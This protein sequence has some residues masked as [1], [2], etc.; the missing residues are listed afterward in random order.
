MGRDDNVRALTAP[1]AF[2]HI[3]DTSWFDWVQYNSSIEQPMIRNAGEAMGVGA[4]VNW[5]PSKGPLFTSTIPPDRLYAIE[6]RL[7]GPKQPR[8]AQFTGWVARWPDG[9][10]RIDGS[11]APRA[12][13]L[14]GQCQGCHLRR[15]HQEFCKGRTDP[16]QDNP[17][18]T[19]YRSHGRPRLVIGTTNPPRHECSNCQVS[20]A[21][22]SPP[23]SAAPRPDYG[24]CPAL[25]QAVE[26]P[27]SRYD[28]H[29]LRTR[30]R[31]ENGFRRNE[32]VPTSPT[33]GR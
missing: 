16:A 11:L 3:W 26:K 2:P 15:R 24:F 10:S 31:P 21:S 1:V 27:Q 32:S 25:G 4:K 8:T 18:A 14:Q 29:A 33:R 19:L 17:G 12:P 20:A 7:A 13:P 22:Y 9:Y 28:Y 23:I 30:P 5:N 6:S